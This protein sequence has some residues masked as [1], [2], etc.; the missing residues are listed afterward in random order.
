SDGGTDQQGGAV[1]QAHPRH[2]VRRRH[3]LTER[4]HDDRL[5]PQDP[6]VVLR[7]LPAHHRQLPLPALPR[8]RLVNP[9]VPLSGRHLPPADL[10][11]VLGE[12]RPPASGLEGVLG[13]DFGV[14]RLSERNL[15][16]GQ[17]R[18]KLPE[19]GLDA[20][21]GGQVVAHDASPASIAGWSTSPTSSASSPRCQ[22]R[23]MSLGASGVSRTVGYGSPTV[24]ST[25]GTSTSSP[26][27]RSSQP[28]SLRTMSSTVR[29]KDSRTAWT[30]SCG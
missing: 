19:T 12:Q 10:G 8:G 23:A 3:G 2:L 20:G 18:D 11:A 5:I 9:G 7:G 1:S 22:A 13:A 16:A 6:Q 4:H 30:S 24:T 29:L 15:G 27:S 25:P 21:G 26:V 17:I 28:P 14:A